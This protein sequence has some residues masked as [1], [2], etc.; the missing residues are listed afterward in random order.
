MLRL[1]AWGQLLCGG[2]KTLDIV[3]ITLLMCADGMGTI[4]IA[5]EPL[6]SIVAMMEEELPKY[7]IDV[8]VLSE[9]TRK[10][11][12]RLLV[13]SRTQRPPAPGRG[14]RSTADTSCA[15]RTERG[16]WAAPAR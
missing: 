11:A 8:L 12:C 14:G 5:S 6:Q 13:D 15:A 4:V 1:G 2:G 16:S 10:W 3:L 7:G 9:H